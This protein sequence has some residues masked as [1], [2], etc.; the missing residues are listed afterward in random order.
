MVLQTCFN[1][2]QQLQLVIGLL[3]PDVRCQLVQFSHTVITAMQHSLDCCSVKP[4]DSR[5]T[6]PHDSSV[7]SENMTPITPFYEMIYSFWKSMNDY[8]SS[9]VYSFLLASTT[10]DHSIYVNTSISSLT[11][12]AGNDSDPPRFLNCLYA[13]LH[14]WPLIPSRQT[15]SL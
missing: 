7:S 10:L 6:L 13:C 5:P 2:P 3:P 15:F 12:L 9:S 14:R 1:I 8:S 11:T 4:T